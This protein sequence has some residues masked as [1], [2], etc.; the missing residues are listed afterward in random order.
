M[1]LFEL[2][3]VVDSMKNDKMCNCITK[4]LFYRFIYEDCFYNDFLQL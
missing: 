3:Y 4:N 1:F 2:E